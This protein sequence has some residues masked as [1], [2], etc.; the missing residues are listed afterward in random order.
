MNLGFNDLGNYIIILIIKMFDYINYFTIS[1]N[2]C[3]VTA[4][5]S[6]KY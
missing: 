1:R 6:T 3:H 5:M 4:V 2:L